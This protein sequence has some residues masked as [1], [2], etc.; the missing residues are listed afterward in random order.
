VGAPDAAVP[1]QRDLPQPLPPQRRDVEDVADHRRPAGGGLRGP[2]RHHRGQVA[3]PAVSVALDLRPAAVGALGDLV[4]L[5]EAVLAELHGVEA[6]GVVEGQA[7]DVAVALGQ[8]RR[9][10][11]AC[12]LAL[13]GDPQDLA[14][15][16]V[17]VLGQRGVAGVAGA[18]VQQPSGP[19]ASRP[20][21]WML[22]LGMPV[23]TGSTSSGE[24]SGKRTT[25]L[26][27]SVV[28]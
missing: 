23:S 5:V 13:R 7:L 9:A 11:D 18:D 1:V 3:T 2:P 25:R 21:L 15:E 4:H 26:S 22:P 17:V 19:K 28:T 8:H 24:D 10:A 12:R 20:P 14:A 27:S 6:A 16:G